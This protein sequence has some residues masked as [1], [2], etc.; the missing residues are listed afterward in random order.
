VKSKSPLGTVLGLGGHSGTH[1]WWMQRV[2][3]IALALLGPWFV[4]R[5]LTLPDYGYA[6]VHATLA[7]PHN[8]VLMILLLITVAHHSAAGV[9]V[10]IE[11]YVPSKG[12]KLAALV[13]AQFLHW[14]LAAYAV[15]AVLKVALGSA[16]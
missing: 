10:V 2:T 7:R 5:A 8:A 1:H 12:K 6:T 3:S 9:A 15:L 11:D 14:V 16:A 13:V 4:V